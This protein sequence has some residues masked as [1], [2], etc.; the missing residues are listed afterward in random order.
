MKSRSVVC[1][2]MMFALLGAAQAVVYRPG[3][4]QGQYGCAN[5]SWPDWNQN[6]RALA[7]NATDRTSGSIMADTT[8]SAV[9]PVS[10]KTWTWP[11]DNST[12]GYEGYIWM[13]AGV[14]YRLFQCMDDGGAIRLEGTFV[15]QMPTPATSGYN[16]GVRQ[17]TMS[18]AST[19]WHHIELWTYDWSGG[20]G[21]VASKSGSST[22]GL[23]WNTNG[24]TTVN[25]TTT[26]DGTWTRFRDPGDMT[27]L[28]TATSESFMRLNSVAA[29][30]DDLVASMTFTAPTNAT[31]FLLH[32]DESGG[33]LG[34]QSWDFQTAV[35]SIAPGSLTTNIVVAGLDLESEPYACFYLRS[36]PTVTGAQHVFEEW[37]VPFKASSAPSSAIS[38]DAIDYTTAS[39]SA[40]ALSMGLGGTSADL[41]VEI[42][43]DAA[44]TAIVNTIAATNGILSVPCS[45]SGIVN[46]TALVTN[47]TY[48]ARAKLVNQ[49]S[50]V[51]YSAAVSFTTLNPGAPVVSGFSAG[52]GFDTGNF[53]ASLVSYGDGSTNALLYVDVSESADFVA[54]TAFGPSNIVG[55][56]PA[57]RAL[58]ATALDNGTAYYARI[59]AVNSWGLTGVSTTI[60]FETRQEPW[61]VSSIG[62]T[63]V[64]GGTQISMSIVELVPGAAVDA[65]LA[66]GTTEESALQVASWNGI[67]TAPSAM[68]YID[69]ASSGTYVAKYTVTSTYSGTPY[70]MKYTQ[71][72]TV[73]RNIYVAATLE[74]LVALRLKVGESVRLPAL[75]T[76][77]DFYR[78]LNVRVATLGSGGASLTAVGPG[79]TGVEYHAYD[80]ALGA[81]ALDGTGGLIVVPEPIGSGKVYLFKENAAAWNWNDAANW[82]CVSDP[83]HAGYPDAIDDVAMILYYSQSS[84][85]MTVGS[86]ADPSVTIG[87]LYAGQLKSVATS[88]R[89]QGGSS[90]VRT[91]NFERSNG[92]PARIQLT[93]GAWDSKTFYLYLGGNGS[94]ERLT[95]SASSDI[96]FDDG[97]AGVSDTR[98]RNHGQFNNYVTVV[99]PEGRF[100]RLTGG[101]PVN[102]GTGGTTFYFSGN[103]KFV[104]GG[105]LWNA[106]RLNT[107]IGSDFSAF[108]GTIRDSG[109]G[110][111][112]YDRNANFQFYTTSTTNATLELRGFVTSALSA[113]ASAGYSAWGTDHF[114]GANGPTA[115]RTPKKG[116]SLQGGILHYRQDESSAWGTGSI[117]TNV[118]D[119]LT[120]GKGLSYVTLSFRGPSTGQPTNTVFVPAMVNADKGALIVSEQNAY[121]NLRGYHQSRLALED[122]AAHAIG[123]SGNPLVES[124]YPIVPWIVQ[125]TNRNSGNPEFAAVDA[126]GTLVYPVLTAA[127]L[128]TVVDP[129]A[130]AFCYNKSMALSSDRTVNS[131]LV[132]N[133]ATDA[134]SRIGEGRTLT[135]SSGGLCFAGNETVRI[136]TQTGGPTNGT[137]IFSRTA[138]IF[139][140]RPSTTDPAQIHARILAP[141]GL[142]FC[143]YGNLLLS[144]DQTGIDGEI[145]VNNGTLMLGS[146]D[147]AAK[148]QIDADVRIV[149]G[150]ST[151]KVNVSGTLNAVNVH[152]DDVD[153]FSGKLELPAGK[154]E[155]CRMLFIGDGETSMPRGTYGSS[156]SAAEFVD[157]AHFIG[158][159]VLAVTRDNLHAPSVISIR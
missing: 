82:E 34:V 29:V 46:T 19:G 98:Q 85:T 63:A 114:Y 36:A 115:N 7:A 148:A 135:V 94:T 54:Y 48:Y 120:A 55:Q 105:V 35:A 153:R 70:S 37:H 139:S 40:T 51:G 121:Y 61:A 43:T 86:T 6:L 101:N 56:L 18:A 11:T 96:V 143:G 65:T 72:F 76:P 92:E 109:Y 44:F 97:Y 88:L 99:L 77:Q 28:K 8:S 133:L 158:T 93:G 25:A 155:T 47:T 136:G 49:N 38:V 41:S 27:F 144:G 118:T 67:A 31:L 127:A 104:G 21:P 32:G 22:M 4:F 24:S 151:V 131:L 107:N 1:L 110:H 91:L 130:N 134:N 150:A 2:A 108:T 140:G 87:E 119:L 81:T 111:G 52:V 30:G 90:Q 126:S 33:A 17:S 64:A 102:Y 9:N 113:T 83:G 78:V 128:D 142:A 132:R 50:A 5:S 15:S 71:T 95:V 75:A 147:G 74:D 73:G 57:G 53:A 69:G 116:I 59:R 145:V 152:F 16:D 39:F 103:T 26:S 141:E 89:L 66:I 117:M 146:L 138:Y 125:R 3:L 79:G 62:A 122:F 42:A 137:L 159:G 106:S 157:D 154:T 129:A 124:T 14:T 156:A 45:V 60:P 149:S 58:V 68:A 10:G 84:K 100:I 13:D 23:A 112:G 20:K 123:G 12:F 80:P